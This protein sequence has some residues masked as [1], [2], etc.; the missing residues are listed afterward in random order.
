MTG[1]LQKFRGNR[2]LFIRHIANSEREI[3]DLLETFV[4]EDE[5]DINQ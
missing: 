1:L 4:P 2:Q 3:F 5:Y